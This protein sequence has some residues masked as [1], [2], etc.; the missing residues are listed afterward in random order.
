MKYCIEETHRKKKQLYMVSID[1]QKAFDPVNRGRLIDIMKACKIHQS[2]LAVIAGIYC[3]DETS[4]Y[5][6]SSTRRTWE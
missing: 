5:L 4:L 1:F 6:T 2:I 3:G